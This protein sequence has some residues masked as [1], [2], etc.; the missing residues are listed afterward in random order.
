MSLRTLRRDRL[1]EVAL[2]VTVALQK[3]S[4]LRLP[5]ERVLQEELQ[6]G[7]EPQLQQEEDKAQ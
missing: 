6:K 3:A 1:R 5:K 4:P 7:K 2:S